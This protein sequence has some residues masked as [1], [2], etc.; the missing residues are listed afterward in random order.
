VSRTRIMKPMA[1]HSTAPTL[2]GNAKKDR[3][4]DDFKGRPMTGLFATLSP[5]QQA[6]AL[7]Y[8]GPVGS[9]STKL[10]RI[11]KRKT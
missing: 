6:R 2:R 1:R 7:A 10:P 5:E 3:G 9:G 11:K 4:N 8:E